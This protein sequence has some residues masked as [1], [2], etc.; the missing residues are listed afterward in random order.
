MSIQSI[1]SRAFAKQRA[2]AFAA[3]AAL[4]LVA[5]PALALYKVVGPDGKIIY[6]DRPPT[7]RPVQSIRS[8]GSVSAA[9]ALP[10]ELRQVASRFPVTLYSGSGCAPCDQGRQWLKARGVPFTEKTVNSNADIDA[11]QRAEGVQQLPVLRVGQQRLQGFSDSEWATYIDAAGY[12]KASKLPATYQYPTPSPL[13][14]ASSAAGAAG[15]ADSAAAKAS[16]AR[17]KAAA[18]PANTNNNPSSPPG[19]RF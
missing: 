15:K 9:D 10:F 1:I 16:A 17:A 8:N 5:S 12:P 18:T 2:P 7:D 3:A 13:A 11:L 19:F 6:T 14:P 4:L